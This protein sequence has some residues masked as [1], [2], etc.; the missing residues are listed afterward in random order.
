MRL[1]KKSKMVFEALKTMKNFIPNLDY[2]YSVYQV[3][4]LKSYL[5]KRNY[6]KESF[7]N[8]LN[9]IEKKI[10]KQVYFWTTNHAGRGIA[11]NR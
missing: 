11:W 6:S 1:R 5:K 8:F 9:Q 7:S 4:G 3:C 10:G 2:K